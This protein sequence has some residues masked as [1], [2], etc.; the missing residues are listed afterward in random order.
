MFYKKVI[1]VNDYNDKQVKRLTANLQMLEVGNLNL[2]LTID[3]AND[4]I[5]K[6]H[7]MKNF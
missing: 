6:S 1:E 5:Q 2:D 4:N 7:D 3:E